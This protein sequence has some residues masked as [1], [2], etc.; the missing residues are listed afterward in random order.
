MTNKSN[1][2]ITQIFTNHVACAWPDLEDKDSTVNKTNP[3]TLWVP[4]VAE[5]E[6]AITA[7][8]N[9][10]CLGTVQVPRESKAG[11]DSDW[12]KAFQKKWCLNWDPKN[13]QKIGKGWGGRGGGGVE[14]KRYETEQVFAMKSK[15]R[16]ETEPYVN[17]DLRFF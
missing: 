5:A 14:V 15:R 1:L 9:K 3:Q 16:D 2:Y 8:Y 6:R 12:G 13:K 4:R 10:R 11:D 7:Q 17:Q